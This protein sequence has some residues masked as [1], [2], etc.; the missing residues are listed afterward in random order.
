M[1]ENDQIKNNEIIAENSQHIE[2]NKITE[3]KLIP[4]EEEEKITLIGN[5]E[6]DE[7]TL[8]RITIVLLTQKKIPQSEIKKLL[9]VSKAL[10]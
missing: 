6:Y 7:D 4:L 9:G 1:E 8:N 5:K 10:P 2:E 3:D